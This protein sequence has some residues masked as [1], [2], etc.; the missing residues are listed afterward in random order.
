[1]RKNICTA[2]VMALFVAGLW[3]GVTVQCRYNFISV[4]FDRKLSYSEPLLI[5]VFS[6]L[7]F[8]AAITIAICVIWYLSSEICGWL[9]RLIKPTE[10]QD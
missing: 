8:P 4:V 5:V 7:F 10:K 3:F 1:M 6:W 9:Q 2:S